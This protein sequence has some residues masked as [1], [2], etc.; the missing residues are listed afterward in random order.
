MDHAVLSPSAAHR[1]MTCPAS[2]RMARD[3]PDE[4]S[5]SVYALEGTQFHTLCEVEASR[6]ILGREPSE[7]ALEFLDWALETEDEWHDD[8]LRYV[9]QWI[10]L[11]KEYLAEEEGAQLFLEVRVDTGVPGSWGTADAV[12]VYSDWIRVI[13]IKYGMGQRISA[14]ENPQLRLY[15]VGSLEHLVE[16]P[17]TIKEVWNTIWQPRL[18]NLS[19]ENLTRAALVKWRDDLI[20]TARLALSEDA[21]FGPSEDACRYCPAAGICAPRARFMLAQD[22]GDPDVLTGEEL[23]DAFSRTSHLKRW[24][25]DIEDAALKRAFE[26]AGSVPGFK[27]VQ[28]GGRRKITDEQQAI[29]TLIAEGFDATT[30]SSTKIA[31][32]G[33]LD[34]LVGEEE[35]QRVLGDLLVKSEGRL[36]LA[37]ESDPRPPADALHSAK[38]DFAEIENGEA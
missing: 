35:L 14:L 33:Q 10:T 24:I 3:I 29:K 26:E 30:V 23:A 2:I 1:W 18:N 16:D 20:P 25:A 17:L 28:S 9:E 38:T 27:V 21:P 31:T 32:L 22:F 13:D 37:K 34:K 19:E 5:D 8:Q 15:G 7:Y 36:S 4:Q 6:R 12:I 11:L